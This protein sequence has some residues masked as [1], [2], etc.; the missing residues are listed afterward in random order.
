MKL[1]D[2]V[3][4]DAPLARLAVSGGATHVATAS[5]RVD[6][7]NAVSVISERG[8]I[9]QVP[10]L[11][12]PSAIALSPTHTHS[13]QSEDDTFTL[14][15]GGE[16]IALWDETEQLLAYCVPELFTSRDTAGQCHTPNESPVWSVTHLDWSTHNP[17]SLLVCHRTGPVCLYPIERLPA[18]QHSWRDAR[19]KPETARSFFSQVAK[20]LASKVFSHSAGDAV[21]PSRP[22][23]PGGVRPKSGPLYE[24]V[25]QPLVRSSLPGAALVPTHFFSCARFVQPKLA[26]A[27]RNGSTSLQLL[28]FRTK[29]ETVTWDVTLTGISQLRVEPSSNYVLGLDRQC[30]AVHVFD[31]RK[32]ERN[33]LNAIARHNVNHLFD[34]NTIINDISWNGHDPDHIYFA[35]QQQRPPSHSYEW[36]S[37][38]TTSLDALLDVKPERP[39]FVPLE[40]SG[41]I[42]PCALATGV[43]ALGPN[44]I[45]VTRMIGS[46]NLED[47]E[48]L[49]QIPPAPN[50]SAPLRNMK[51]IANKQWHLSIAGSEV[52]SI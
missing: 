16:A 30:G 2:S 43:E 15:V 47:P 48:D 6:G 32:S 42:Q 31:Y 52:K 23:V 49:V 8:D 39:K 44:K 24:P 9:K 26:V 13:T 38:A 21:S 37:V 17:G 19:R 22:G 46:W 40:N 12:P 51:F 35:L 7:A 3:R 45:A 4:F 11:F 50:A 20:T 25:T 10:S 28:D 29:P 33:C 1:V 14:A 36:Q 34:D 5:A 18:A 27:S 41:W